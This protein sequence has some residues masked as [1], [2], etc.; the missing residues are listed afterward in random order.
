MEQRTSGKR[1]DAQ[2]G[3]ID[4]LHK[5][6]D[7]HCCQLCESQCRCIIILTSVP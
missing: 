6:G 4:I 5:V 2:K 3:K 7:S 1:E